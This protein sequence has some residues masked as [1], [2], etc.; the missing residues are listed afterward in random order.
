LIFK[1]KNKRK[2][3][4]FVV[5][6]LVL[7]L[8]VFSVILGLKIL[9]K[10]KEEKE[11]APSLPEQYT[12]EPDQY[13]VSRS[14]NPVSVV[15]GKAAD[16]AVQVKR[17]GGMVTLPIPL[18]VVVVF[19][20]SGSMDDLGRN[21]SEPINSAKQAAKLFV[22]NLNF[23][24]DD[25]SD[26]VALVKYSERADLSLSFSTDKD[27]IKQTIDGFRAS[28]ATNIG[29]ALFEA[30]EILAKEAGGGQARKVVV[31]LTDGL[32]NRTHQGSRCDNWPRQYNKCTDDALAQAENLKKN[33]IILYAIGL[34]FDGIEKIHPGS[35]EVGKNLLGQ[36]ATSKGHFYEAPGKE[37]LQLIYQEIG[38]NI[39]D[40]VTSSTLT[41][42]VNKELE[43]IADSASPEPEAIDGNKITWVWD[44]LE[45]GKVKNF[46]YQV[47]QKKEPGNYFVNQDGANLSYLE[48]DGATREI[49]LATN[50]SLTVD[51]GGTCPLSSPSPSPSSL[52]SP[53]VSPSP[54]LPQMLTQAVDTSPSPSPSSLISPVQAFPLH[55][56]QYLL[57]PPAQAL[58][59]P[60]RPH[61]QQELSLRRHQALARLPPLPPVP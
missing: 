31:L 45:V 2:L 12:T 10:K 27:K 15:C 57:L 56:E 13:E 38:T 50:L 26:K 39:K 37:D 22:D 7:T 48:Y 8:L 58:L 61:H 5:S 55:Q 49:L 25:S 30:N 14:I 54:S 6:L 35:G 21:P 17:V 4:I 44:T 1:I 16:V 52:P 11:V 34:D 9:E 47:T 59:L 43:I 53:S 29:D 20:V 41:E 60:L 28:G 24:A 32:P 3:V 40:V 42:L 19:D 18:N 23:S 46:T 33:N 36:L 51:S